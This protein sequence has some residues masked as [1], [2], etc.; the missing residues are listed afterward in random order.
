MGKKIINDPDKVV[1]ELLEGFIGAYSRFYEKHPDVNGII[2]KHRKKNKVSL[3]IGGGS[4]HEPLFPGFVGK[5]LAD[6]AAC[7]N[8]FTS[9]DPNTIY[10][11][12]RTVDEGKGILFVYGCY[13]GDNM[14]FDVGEEFLNDDGIAT[15][16][17][18][19]QD[20]I[21]SAPI[22][23]KDE[24]RGI[25]GDIFVIKVAGAACES[26]L[27]LRE[28]VRVTEKAR[29]NV[30]SVGIATASA[31]LPGDSKP[32]F[33]LGED[34]IEYGMGLHGERGVIRTSMQPADILVD[35]MYNQLMSE[36][37]LKAGDEVCVLVNGLGATSVME[38]A[39]VFR[40]LK[41]LLDSEGICIHDSDLNSYCTSQGMG[42]F[43]ISLFKLDEELKRYYDMPCYCPFYSKGQWSETGITEV[44]EEKNIPGTALEEK[45]REGTYVPQKRTGILNKLDVS[46]T[47]DMFIY[48][49]DK[50]I[51]RKSYLT[52]ID[53]AM[54][55]GDHG[56]GMAGGMQKVKA[57]LERM[58][59]TGNV[60]EVFEVAG[61]A[62]LLSMGGASGVLFGEI[63]LAGTRGMKPKKEL[64]SEDLAVMMRKSLEA[65]QKRGKAQPGDKTMVDALAPAVEALEANKNKSLLVM[66]TAAEEAARQGME[67]TKNYM[68]KFGRARFLMSRVIGHQ[69]AGATSVWLIFQ[70]M[71]EFVE[72]I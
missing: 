30:K 6:A 45:R 66:L 14:N 15:A 71:R 47:K 19:V 46:Y 50:V 44:P 28:V 33:E 70:G 8:I 53:R 21:V 9:P 1:P 55:D 72:G 12:A 11:I 56:I 23:R 38:L 65:I 2:F 32:L 52:E 58:A 10:Q 26:G 31:Q 24:R 43:S 61:K 27:S 41:Q 29:D 5:G 54:G 59:D 7:G 22:E 37:D 3:V 68:A 35:R 60:Y 42:G 67:N 4:G 13:T 57:K 34:E 63:Y 40:R 16:R 17:V 62:M 39:I 48:I 25:A 20:D 69:D 18:R 36:F 51:G 64:S 49:A